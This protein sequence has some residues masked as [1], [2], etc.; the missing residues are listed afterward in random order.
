MLSG[1]IVPQ[2]G[3]NYQAIQVVFDCNEVDVSR[4]SELLNKITKLIDVIEIERRSRA[5]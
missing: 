2:G 1:L 5:K 4:R 3:Y